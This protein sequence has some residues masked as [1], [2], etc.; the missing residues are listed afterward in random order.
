MSWDTGNNPVGQISFRTN[1]R[2]YGPFGS[3]PHGSSKQFNEA[4]DGELLFVFSEARWLGSLGFGHGPPATG[5]SRTM[6]E[7]QVGQSMRHVEEVARM[8]S[9]DL[10][11]KV[12]LLD[13]RCDTALLA[14]GRALDV[15]RATTSLAG[16][17]KGDGGV[18][19]AGLLKG[20]P[21]N[22]RRHG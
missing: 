12:S 10:P 14:L 16:L 8:G 19:S 1:T 7:Q 6:T 2:T 17:A 18:R 13:Y 5:V 11:R 4:F 22:S 20:P 21:N 3:L 15:L 9:S